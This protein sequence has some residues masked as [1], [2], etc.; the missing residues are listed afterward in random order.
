V[1]IKRVLVLILLVILL[2][3]QALAAISTTII[4]NEITKLSHYG[5]DYESGNINYAQLIVYISAVRQDINS[6]LRK[7]YLETGNPISEDEIEGILGKASSTTTEAWSGIQQKSVQLERPFKTWNKLVFDGKKIQI[8][9]DVHPELGT[10]SGKEFAGEVFSVNLVFKIQNKDLSKSSLYEIIDLV[11]KYE[12]ESTNSLAKEIAEKITLFEENVR[13]SIRGTS[14]CEE[15]MDDLLGKENRTER[16]EV[17]SYKIRLN[18]EDDSQAMAFFQYCD[19]CESTGRIDIKFYYQKEGEEQKE[20]KFEKEKYQGFDDDKYEYELIN[21]FNEFVK[22]PNVGLANKMNELSSSWFWN[23]ENNQD[24]NAQKE[25]YEEIKNYFIE[26]FSKYSQEKSVLWQREYIQKIYLSE[27]IIELKEEYNESCKKF[28]SVQCNGKVIFKGKDKNGCPLEPICISQEDICVEDKDCKQPLCGESKCVEGKC[29][30][31]QMNECQKA[32]CSYGDIDYMKCA[33]GE[34][35]VRKV[36][37]EGKWK[38]I[39]QEC[40]SLSNQEENEEEANKL[41]CSS[42]S[43]CSSSEV[44][45]NGKCIFLPEKKQEIS[46]KEEENE[47]N[48]LQEDKSEEGVEEDKESDEEENEEAITVTGESVDEEENEEF[49]KESEE[50]EKKKEEQNSFN[51]IVLRGT[52][53]GGETNGKG[54]IQSDGTLYINLEGDFSQIEEKRKENS[55]SNKD[56]WCV[57]ELKNAI[58]QRKELEKTFNNEFVK[59]FFEEYLINN[60]DQ[61]VMRS[62]IINDFYNIISMSNEFIAGDTVCAGEYNIPKLNP[63]EIEYETSFGSLKFW[64]KTIKAKVFRAEKEVDVLSPYMTTWIW[65]EKEFLKKS[66]INNSGMIDSPDQPYKEGMLEEKDELRE[67]KRLVEDVNKLI[68]KYGQED[69]KIG[70]RFVDYEDNTTVVK[71]ILLMDKQDILSIKP[72]TENIETQIDVKLDFNNLYNLIETLQK[73]NKE[74]LVRKPYWDKNVDVEQFF[75]NIKAVIKAWSGINEVINSIEVTPESARKDLINFAVSFFWDSLTK[76]QA[77]ENP[78]VNIKYD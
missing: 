74:S 60:A 2:S 56:N 11:K 18:E 45:S 58:V 26:L 21:T 28:E 61:W 4:P 66:L 9:V 3:Q 64:E 53:F 12:N 77:G 7:I 10:K 30:I 22:T 70:I 5:E 15:T 17:N 19:K 31:N 46:E 24:M 25:R 34:V 23:K 62:E 37:S 63:I 75:Q 14:N 51:A 76:G 72:N 16:N 27:K 47:D 41:E 59:W 6:Q 55:N 73:D 39:E 20:E 32:E 44:C 57:G 40:K 48:S 42:I 65:P 8:I 13:T 43:D 68:E 54:G 49:E 69:L 33:S 67:R 38:E 71:M 78:E 50:K 35:L 29:E 52:C 36:C 1:K